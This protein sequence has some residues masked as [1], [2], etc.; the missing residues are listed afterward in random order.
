MVQVRTSLLLGDQ[1]MRKL[2]LTC[3]I[4]VLLIF[5]GIILMQFFASAL[6]TL[7]YIFIKVFLGASYIDAAD[8]MTDHLMWISAISAALSMIWCLILYLRSS[9]RVQTIDYKEV[10]TPK[11]ILYIL[12]TGVG[13]CVT[14]TVFLS[15][16]MSLIPQAF[17]NYNEIMKNLDPNGGI[18]TLIYVLLIGPASEE[19][20]FRGAI[21][22]RTRLAF[23]FW[24]GNALQALLF[25]IYHMN[26]IQG[27]YAFLL[28]I[29]LGMVFYA[30]DSILC[31]IA[32]HIIFNSTTY[33]IQYIFTGS[34]AFVTG[35][36]VIVILL[37]IIMLIAS[38]RY[39]IVKC[40][41]KCNL[42]K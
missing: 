34:S 28:G 25:G 11:N 6:Y 19:I 4:K 16:I 14:L 42:K 27:I 17:E 41:N 3:S 38:L 24:T 32:T 5:G 8:G 18:L 1:N 35:L 33:I 30:T 36:F 40:N 10:F 2:R 39:F 26:L 9:W 7:G 21:F 20:I 37:S 23:G 31:S 12:E 22:D 15:V 13:G 29:V